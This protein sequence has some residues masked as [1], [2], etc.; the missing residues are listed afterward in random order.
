M[1]SLDILPT[2]HAADDHVVSYLGVT[3]IYI[4]IN[5][6]IGD[7]RN[8]LTVLALIVPHSNIDAS[9]P[10]ILGTLSSSS[11]LQV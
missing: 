8:K 10:H 5:N 4:D 3:E 11:V 2:V 6:D 9:V 1:Q 7:D